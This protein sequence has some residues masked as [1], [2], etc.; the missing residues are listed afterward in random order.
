M[1]CGVFTGY[2]NRQPIVVKVY[3]QKPTLTGKS[4]KTLGKNTVTDG[5]WL[6]G[7]IARHAV[8]KSR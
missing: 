6:A 2:K 4:W 5:G 8:T 7:T 3:C 1:C